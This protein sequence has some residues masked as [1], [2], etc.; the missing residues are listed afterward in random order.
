VPKKTIDQFGPDWIQPGNIVTNGWFMLDTWNKNVNRIFVK[1]PLLPKD[2]QETYG[3]NVERVNYTVV[4]DAGT[5]YAK[6]QNNEVDATGIP[7]GE[8]AKILADPELSKNVTRAYDLSL[9]YFGFAFDKPPFDNVHARRAFSA[10]IDRKGL[11]ADLV[12]GR[13]APMA[14]FMPPGIFGS[15]D[16]NEIGV[17]DP[18]NLGFDPDYAK[19]EFAAAGYADCSTFPTITIIT[20]DPTWAEYL[21]N[22]AKTHLGCD[23]SKITIQQAEFQVK[24][25][26]IKPD[27]PTAQRPNMWLSVWGPDYLDAQNWMHDVLSC[28][29]ENSFLRPCDANDELIDAA[30]KELDSDKRA[31]DY[32]QLE[33]NFFSN[34]G[35]FPVAPIYTA[36]DLS[37]AKPWYKGLFESDALLGG[38]H[39]E[40]RYIDQAAQL[41]ARP[42]Q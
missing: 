17:G 32:R 8:Q 42:A 33:I 28:K 7:R 25:Q 16:I 13:G 20:E 30:S 3:G 35:E 19:K 2:F 38:S 23:P 31:Q 11:V 9:T 29:S 24:E 41:A 10:I 1:N 18:K 14:H 22:Q 6:F 5:V 21:Q 27:V 34:D 39:W 40:T 36:L 12:G 37:L 26:S 15:V 4:R